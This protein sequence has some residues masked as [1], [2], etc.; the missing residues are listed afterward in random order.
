[1]Q[2]NLIIAKCVVLSI[3]K[4]FDP[5]GFITP[6]LMSAKCIFQELWT[7]GISWDEEISGELADRFAEWIAGLKLLKNMR[8]SRQ[9]FRKSHFQTANASLVW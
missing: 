9:Y 5:I 7:L 6:F 4:L 3:A 8:I 2:D 1:M